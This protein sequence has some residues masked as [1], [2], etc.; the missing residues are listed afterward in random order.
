VLV[1][2]GFKKRLFV[3]KMLF[4]LQRL[5]DLKAHIGHRALEPFNS[6]KLLGRRNQVL[7]HDGEQTFVS[8]QRA[9]HFIFFLLRDQ[10]SVGS[11]KAQRQPRILF[12]NTNPKYTQITKKAALQTGQSYVSE[13]WVGGTLTNWQQVQHS[14]L[15]YQVFSSYFSDFLVQQKIKFPLYEKTKKR[16]EGWA[17][18]KARTKS[19]SFE[20]PGCQATKTKKSF[21]PASHGHIDV[22]QDLP[23]PEINPVVANQKQAQVTRLKT[24]CQPTSTSYKSQVAPEGLSRLEPK[25]LPDLIISLNPNEQLVM[26]H[27]AATLKIPVLCLVDSNFKPTRIQY[28]VNANDDSVRFVYFF[29]NA[30]I[31]VIQY[32]RLCAARP[33]N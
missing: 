20:N 11:P 6:K 1:Q 31:R 19:P 8:F 30:I 32:A 5:I 27:E 17:N 28:G 14:I 21:H 25:I 7:I 15:T 4:N 12:V 2:G 16:F 10:G 23:V 13:F 3:F 33:A 24:A 26:L 9:L 29:L 22:Q 18:F